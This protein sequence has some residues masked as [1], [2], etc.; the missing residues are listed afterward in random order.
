MPDRRGLTALPGKSLPPVLVRHSYRAICGDWVGYFSNPN[1]A[2]DSA[3][4]R[5]KFAQ[6]G[7]RRRPWQRWSVIDTMRGVVIAEG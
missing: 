2:L 7:T 4:E 3:R 5:A 1:T 6:D